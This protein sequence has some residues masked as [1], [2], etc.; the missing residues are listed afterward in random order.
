MKKVVMIFI[1]MLSVLGITSCGDNEVIK[2][3]DDI[4]YIE[5]EKDNDDQENDDT[6]IEEDSED[7]EYVPEE[8]IEVLEQVW[9]EKTK[10]M[11]SKIFSQNGDEYLYFVATNIDDGKIVWEYKTIPY[12]VYMY[13]N[14]IFLLD[15]N[16]KEKVYV[17]EEESIVLLNLETGK[18]IWRNKDMGSVAN[19][20][21]ILNNNLY[22]KDVFSK[23]IFVINTVTG[24]LVKKI[25][26]P[27]KYNCEGYEILGTIDD[28]ILVKCLV[29]NEF[30][31]VIDLNTNKISKIDMNLN[32]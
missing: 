5:N 32:D 13:E 30:F 11:I 7:D 10:V 1:L 3:Y 31:L 22:A 28:D 6:V 23:E 2:T 21:L 8:Q 20:G 14:G 15:P 26:I 9:L 16:N 17:F 18:V 12:G 27:E 19:N 4:E 24:N 25:V 29:E